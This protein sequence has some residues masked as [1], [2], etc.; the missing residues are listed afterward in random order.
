VDK[1]NTRK[2]TDFFFVGHLDQFRQRVSGEVRQVNVLF[3]EYTPHDEDYHLKNLFHVADEV[4]GINQLEAMNSVELFVLACAL[5]GHDWG[6]A[7]SEAEKQYI[8]TGRPPEG[9]REEDLWT[10]RDERERFTEFARKEGLALIDGGCE[11]IDIILWREYVRQTHAIR[12]GERVRR[13][14][15]QIDTGVAEGVAR[16]CESHCLNFEL[17]MDPHF[18]PTESPILREEV[19]LRALAVYLRLVDLL[20]LGSDRTPYIIWKFVAPRDPR[21]KM[22][23]AKHRALQSVTCSEHQAWRIVHVNGITDDHEIYAALQDLRIYCE[24]QVRGCNDLLVQMHDPR[25]KLN[26]YYINWQV[27]ARGFAPISIQFEFDRERMFEMLSEEIYSGDSHVFLRELLQ[28]SID[29]IRMRHAI[30]KSRG[31]E[32]GDI[33][34]IQV[35]VE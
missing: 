21:A 34:I 18:C 27:E 12:S 20:D 3:P 33:G 6:M 17:L 28:N 30:I 19:N 10:L 29:A 23:W 15:E 14:F 11:D 2:D 32:P 25:H 24:N 5:Y 4:L 9:A 31:F 26:L 22:E 16:V 1:A 7:V 8:V 13:Y 35:T